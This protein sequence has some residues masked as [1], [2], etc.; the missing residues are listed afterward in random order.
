[1]KTNLLKQLLFMATLMVIFSCSNEPVQ[2]DM[3]L[4]NENITQ[5]VQCS[6]DAPKARITNNND[7]PVDLEIFNESGTLV[8]HAYGVQ[9][10]NVSSWRVFATGVTTFVVSTTESTKTIVIDMDVCM[11]YDVTID[12]NNQ[13]DTDQP[14]QL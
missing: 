6:N 3:L 4:S 13:L 14:V 11:A 7:I 10:G 2:P 12:E 1:M 9:P 5:D 8:N